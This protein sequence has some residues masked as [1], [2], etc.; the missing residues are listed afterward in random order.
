MTNARRTQPG[1]D[2]QGIAMISALLIMMI[3]TV[4][5][6]A[7]LALA[8]HSN[9]QSA[10]QRNLTAALHAADYGL[11][12]ELA[13][14]AG[15]PSSSGASCTPI[16][17]GI[18]PNT[19]LPTQ[20][21]TVLLPGCTVSSANR[22]IIATGYAL[23]A[24]SSPPATAPATAS[25]R[26]VVAH[27]TLQPAGAISNGGYGFPDAILA[28]KSGG[29]GGLSAA[30]GSPLTI[31]ADGPESIRSVGPVAL[32]NGSLPLS[33]GLT[34]A[35]L[36]SWDN[37]TLA[38]N[39][40]TG[41]VVSAKTVTLTSSNVS[42]YVEGTAISLLGTPVSTVGSQRVGTVQLPT[43]PPVPNFNYSLSDWLSLTGAGS[44]TTTCPASGGTLTG[45]Y[46]L[47]SGCTVSPAAIG[48]GAVAIIVNAAGNLNLTLPSYTGPGP[49]QLYLIATNGNLTLSDSGASAQVF[50]YGSG[51]V[52]VSGTIVGQLAGGTV[53]TS[54]ATNL[55]TQLVSTTVS[56]V[57]TYPPDFAF[58]AAG[59]GP[60]PT[61]F[62]PLLNDEYLC[63]P[64]ATTAC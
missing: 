22:T 8:V 46:V 28:L 45:L 9:G 64:G 61:G 14:L 58:P 43:Q 57:V 12:E 60:T 2:E 54:A 51:T 37:I 62:V 55:I 30:S 19:S 52:T 42:G 11:Q 34:T 3:C 44:A 4:V 18:L 38:N 41:N 15:Q 49:S 16:S 35:S 17:G 20:W 32:S 40:V 50:A 21:F 25:A 6:T 26:T 7:S 1:R 33:S 31:T 53:T 5:V 56:G 47:A 24:G 39:P 27:I 48:T 59:A 36:S 13:N 10:D 29:S 23:G 63:A